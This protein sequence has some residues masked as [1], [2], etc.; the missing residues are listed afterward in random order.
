MVNANGAYHVEDMAVPELEVSTGR[1]QP[2]PT[3]DEL[4]A[5]FIDENETRYAVIHKTWHGYERGVWKR[6]E[7]QHEIA[8]L[9]ILKRYKDRG[10]NPTYNKMQG[11]LSIAQ[12][13]L[14]VKD[15][16]LEATRKQYINLKNGMFNLATGQVENHK[17]EMY[18]TSQLDFEYDAN[19]KCPTWEK[20]LCDVFR[21][22]DGYPDWLLIQFLQQAFGYTL[23]GDT[24]YR[25]SFWMVGKSGTGKSTVLNVLMEL[26]GDSHV[27]I[28]LDSLN[29]NEYQLA[30]IAG[31][32]LVTFS[33]VDTNGMLADGHYKRLVSQ[34][35]ITARQPYGKPFRFTPECK[36]WGAMNSLPR[37]KD[38]TDAVFNRVKVIPMNHVVPEDKRDSQLIDKL[39]GE[40]PGIFNWAIA[41]LQDLYEYKGFQEPKA[42]LDAVKDYQESQDT[43]SLFVADCCEVGDGYTV[44]SSDLYASYKLWAKNNGISPKSSN[45]MSL[46]WQRLGFDRKRISRG[47]VYFGVQLTEEAAAEI[48]Q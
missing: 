7:V 2:V 11:V 33:E 37:V 35:V 44:T 5:R 24:Q 29:R 46:E 22:E 18:F 40:M 48:L 38:R 19:A 9:E 8:A 27:T 34:D 15:E 17:R 45:K 23:T 43:E 6:E 4:A 42:I 14:T 1:K 32:R 31:K 47:T 21:K 13:Y 3:D 20:F 12:L 36:V 30:D 16:S 28:D 10:L 26:A 41:G 39:R 25:V